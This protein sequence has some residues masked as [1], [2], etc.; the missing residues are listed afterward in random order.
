MSNVNLTMMLYLNPEL[1]ANSNLTS[2]SLAQSAWTTDQAGAKSLSSLAS[3]Q[4]MTPAGFDPKV[5]VAAQTNVSAVNQT[6]Y[7]AML[8]MGSTLNSILRRGIY[9]STLM[10]EVAL[11]YNSNSGS[12]LGMQLTEIGNEPFRF[13]ASN[14][15]SGDYVRLQR[16]TDGHGTNGVPLYGQ[17]TSVTSGSNFVLSPVSPAAFNL[18]SLGCIYTLSGIRIW[19]I[20]R[21]ALVAYS[22]NTVAFSNA[23]SNAGGNT[24]NQ[25]SFPGYVD[26][27]DVVP[28]SDFN[29]DAYRAMYPDVKLLD[30]SDAYLDYRLRGKRANEYRIANGGDLYNLEAPYAS[31][32]TAGYG[33][34]GFNASFSNNVTVS[35]NLGIGMPCTGSEGGSAEIDAW[36]GQAAGASNNN[37]WWMTVGSNTRLAVAGD[38]F[39]TGTVISLS[40]AR[41]KSCIQPIDNALER[42][43]FLTGY[44]YGVHGSAKRQTGLLAQEVEEALPE[45]VFYRS[46]EGI[47]AGERKPIASVAYGNL[48]GLFV[49][50]INEISHRLTALEKRMNGI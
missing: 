22:R 15:N 48:A 47:L 45:A 42:L 12:R 26:P 21:Q 49:N 18:D 16:R 2:L 40:D 10:Q 25:A 50:A 24:S 31:N 30:F 32:A 3:T 39:A 8:G 11:T 36:E 17:V 33:I 20:E 19:D 7:N 29:L 37:A 44:T 23:L 1:V 5:Y 41:V 35:G 43:S 14:L 6:I 13:S 27:N 28:R 9:V 34:T 38:I 46:S 4:P